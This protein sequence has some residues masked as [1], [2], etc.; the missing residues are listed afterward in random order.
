VIATTIRRARMV[1]PMISARPMTCTAVEPVLLVVVE[2]PDVTHRNGLG[3]QLQRRKLLGEQEIINSLKQRLPQRL[4]LGHQQIQ[5]WR[6]V[7]R[8]TKFGGRHKF[9]NPLPTFSAGCYSLSSRRKLDDLHPTLCCIAEPVAPMI[10]ALRLKYLDADSRRTSLSKIVPLSSGFRQC[11][12]QPLASNFGA[13]PTANG[14]SGR[15]SL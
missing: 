8:C 14:R 4:S 3:L 12:S 1:P 7:H 13:S 5:L 6:T 2:A 11:F 9:K 15:L 10:L